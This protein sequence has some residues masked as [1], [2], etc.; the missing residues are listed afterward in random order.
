MPVG[1]AGLLLLFEHRVIFLRGLRLFF[2]LLHGISLLGFGSNN[3]LNTVT[4]RLER[5]FQLLLLGFDESL[6]VSTAERNSL[7]L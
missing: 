2:D 1:V 7:M 4:I 6:D 3:H 5:L